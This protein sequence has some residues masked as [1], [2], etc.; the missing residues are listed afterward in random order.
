M[1]KLGI[2]GATGYVGAEVIRLLCR[3]K[4]IEIT[5][6]VS[7]SFAGQPFSNVYPSLR[8]IFDKV[9]DPMDPDVFSDKAE[10]FITALP[11][12]VSTTIIPPLL[13]KGK[14]VLD[15][16]ADFR[17]RDKETYEKWYKCGHNA[18]DLIA[19]SV[20]GLPELYRESIKEASLIANPGCYPTC[21]LLGIAPVLKKGLISTE[22]I[23]IDAASGMSGAGRKSEL[24]YS[25]CESAES[26]KPYGVANHRHTPEIEQELSLLAG[27]PVLVSFTPHLLPVKRGML[28]TC[29]LNLAQTAAAAEEIHNL[30][31]EF[32]KDEPFVRVLPLGAL[33]ETRF[34]AGT[35]YADIGLVVDK[36]LNRLI[37]MSALDNLGKGAAGQ[38]VQSLNILAGFDETEGLLSPALYL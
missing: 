18:P 12:G 31:T 23:I 34:V 37:V 38:A 33:P 36:R 27:K 26:F 3:R 28:A 8:G 22:N 29:Y 5:T 6:V 21:T 10:V 1:L 11:H 19:G 20:Y 13:A 16:S 15:H 7:N 2:I 24:A 30:Y 17:F 9:C 25:F 4:D 32:Y 14:K 35:N